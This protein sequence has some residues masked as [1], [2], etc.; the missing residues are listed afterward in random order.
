MVAHW[1]ASSAEAG[2]GHKGKSRLGER[3]LCASFADSGSEALLR[4]LHAGQDGLE[5]RVGAQSVPFWTHF[6]IGH[7]Y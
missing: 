7:V 4:E 6:Q 2:I 3:S 1:P 5:A